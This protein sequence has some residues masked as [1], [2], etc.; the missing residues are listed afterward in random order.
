VAESYFHDLHGGLLV[1]RAEGGLNAW[2][3]EAFVR[4]LEALIDMGIRRV[5][6]DCSGLA[7]ISSYGMGMLVRLHHRLAGRAADVKLA[8]VKS[9]AAQLLS[10]VRLDGLFDLYPDVDRAR[11]AFRPKNPGQR[12]GVQAQTD[13]DPAPAAVGSKVATR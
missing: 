8:G 1:L 4:P 3:A 11:L 7:Y 9:P 6:V 13:A 10:V 5:M 2:T 12:R